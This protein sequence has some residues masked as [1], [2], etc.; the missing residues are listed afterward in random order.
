M[1]LQTWQDIGGYIKRELGWLCGLIASV[2]GAVVSLAGLTPP[3]N[4]R[5]LTISIISTSAFAYFT[6]PY[7]PREVWGTRENG[8]CAVPPASPASQKETP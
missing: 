3:W 1:T 8:N 2:S 4:H 7:Q 5:V 6:K